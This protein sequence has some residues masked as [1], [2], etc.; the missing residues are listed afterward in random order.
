MKYS[1][2]QKFI[3]YILK[4]LVV[5]CA[6]IGIFLSWYGGKD[7]FMGGTHVFM[8]FTIQSNIVIA[9]ISL[10]GM[11]YLMR[12]KVSKG[13]TILKFI[14]TVSIT[15]TGVVF[16]FVLAPTLG[17]GAWAI[18]NILTHV[19]VPAA[20]VLDYLVTGV[21]VNLKYK[22]AFWV[23][24]PPILY[25]IYAG[26]GFVQK[27]EFS[28]GKNYPYFFLDWGSPLGAFGFGKELPFMGCAWWIAALLVFLILVGMIYIAITKLLR[29]IFRI[30]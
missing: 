12:N 25:A 11:I 8:Y 5:V 14:G 21:K 30:K 9:L 16:C 28:P 3:S 2:F 4:F 13:W 1:K 29:V 7:S 24:I 23:I 22:T 15:L 17:K 27:W 20:A 6:I 18:Q 10:I 19:I 26:Y